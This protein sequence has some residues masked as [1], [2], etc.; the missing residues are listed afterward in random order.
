[1]DHP[2]FIEWN[3]LQSIGYDYSHHYLI[4]F[5]KYYSESPQLFSRGCQKIAISDFN[6]ELNSFN[7][8]SSMGFCCFRVNSK[9]WGTRFAKSDA[10]RWVG[11]CIDRII[12]FLSQ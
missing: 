2:Q 7:L 9:S 8:L 12:K 10:S 6:W 5:F 4:W 11:F 3:A 1:C